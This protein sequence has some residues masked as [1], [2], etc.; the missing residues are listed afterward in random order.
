MEVKAT[1]T[2]TKE[3]IEEVE[4]KIKLTYKELQELR[5]DERHTSYSKD[6][7][8]NPNSLP[9][10]TRLSTLIEEIDR[11]IAKKQIESTELLVNDLVKRGLVER[12]ST[13]FLNKIF[14]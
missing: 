5:E 2:R 7:Y 3:V 13:G 11:V 10:K 6:R 12:K 9:S 1:V 8:R 14:K 4:V